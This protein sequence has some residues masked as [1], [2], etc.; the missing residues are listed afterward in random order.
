MINLWRCMQTN[1]LNR[2]EF[3]TWSLG[4]C[5]PRSVMTDKLQWCQKGSE[6]PLNSNLYTSRWCLGSSKENQYLNFCRLANYMQSLVI[7]KRTW[8]TSKFQASHPFM[9][10][11]NKQ[12]KSTPEHEVKP[13]QMQSVIIPEKTHCP[14]NSTIYSHNEAWNPA[15]KLMVKLHWNSPFTW[16]S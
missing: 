1:L 5:K 2:L 3:L 11:G 6:W 9:S 12:R 7:P 14:P 16:N 15:K 10:L 4:H 13:N 8:G